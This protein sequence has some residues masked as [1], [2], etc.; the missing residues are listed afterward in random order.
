MHRRGK[1]EGT[2]RMGQA[3]GVAAGAASHNT[4]IRGCRGSDCDHLGSWTDYWTTSWNVLAA[5]LETQGLLPWHLLRV[6]GRGG[7]CCGWSWRFGLFLRRE[8]S[9]QPGFLSQASNF[10]EISST[11]FRKISES[12]R[13]PE[14]LLV[15]LLYGGKERK[16]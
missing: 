8:S 3:S 10:R 1:M 5:D 7:Q 14:S 11:K 2:L 15:L 13:T 12:H 9:S 6:V 16:R 4:N